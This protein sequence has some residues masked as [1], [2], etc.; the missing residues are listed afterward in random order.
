MQPGDI[1]KI[2]AL[3]NTARYHRQLLAKQ[4]NAS[5]EH[6]SGDDWRVYHRDME[7]ATKNYQL[8]GKL[9]LLNTS[10]ASHF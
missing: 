9:L 4:C 10:A 6:W 7:I 2:K 1:D 3:Y 8:L 5:H